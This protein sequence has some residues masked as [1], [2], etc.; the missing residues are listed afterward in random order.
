MMGMIR[1]PTTESTILPNAPP[2]ITP[3]ARSITLP[4]TANSRNSL[5]MPMRPPGYMNSFA[6]ATGLRPTHRYNSRPSNQDYRFLRVLP[7]IFR[8]QAYPCGGGHA[9]DR[10]RSRRDLLLWP[11]A[12]A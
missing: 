4:L 10:T 2:M 6:Y 11:G 5:A 1:S 9:A 8:Q 12:D 3:T 7:Q